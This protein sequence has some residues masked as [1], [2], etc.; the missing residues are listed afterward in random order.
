MN[1]KDI[2]WIRIASVT[3]WAVG[4]MFIVG[5]FF[6]RGGWSA[7]ISG[8]FLWYLQSAPHILILILWIFAGGVALKWKLLS[9]SAKKAVFILPIALL[10]G[11]GIIFLIAIKPKFPVDYR[12]PHSVDDYI[13]G[14]AI[15]PTTPSIRFLQSS[16]YGW[17]DWTK[18]GRYPVITENDW[19]ISVIDNNQQKSAWGKEYSKDD[20]LEIAEAE[21]NFAK[22]DARMN[23]AARVQSFIDILSER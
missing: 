12:G 20:L 2:S 11:I 1:Q 7:F 6:D 19:I 9:S 10:I 8:N 23:Q 21:L 13:N 15:A 17:E 4:L 16:L 5:G 22:N 18:Q 14:N 3:L